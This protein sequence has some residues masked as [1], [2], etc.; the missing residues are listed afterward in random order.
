MSMALDAWLSIKVSRTSLSLSPDL[1]LLQETMTSSHSALLAFSRLCPGW[2]YCAISSSGL[3]GGILAAWNPHRF[4][5]KS[6]HTVAGIL[7]KGRIRGSSFSL[8]LLNCY[9]PYAN[10]E[11]FWE[12]VVQ[13][14]L[15]NLPNM[16]LAGDLNLTLNGFEV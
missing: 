5:V 3:S 13:G 1:I 6:F 8:S 10:R 14:G 7:L 2:E 9:G 11:S 12:T 4:K 15:L 16:V